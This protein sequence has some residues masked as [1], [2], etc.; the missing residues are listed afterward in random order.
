M[1]L[2][3]ALHAGFKL[4][5]YKQQLWHTLYIR[6]AERGIPNAY[7][8]FYMRKSIGYAGEIQRL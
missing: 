7:V 1:F 6:D 5:L 8:L 3:A 4:L 2:N